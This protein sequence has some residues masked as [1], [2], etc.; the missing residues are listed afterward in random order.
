MDE[1]IVHPK[2]LTCLHTPRLIETHV[3]AIALIE[4]RADET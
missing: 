2:N 4:N 1:I 3:Y